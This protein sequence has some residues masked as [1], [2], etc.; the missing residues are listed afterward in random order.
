VTVTDVCGNDMEAEI[1]YEPPPPLDGVI[2]QLNLP[3]CPGDDVGLEFVLETGVGPFTYDWSSGGNGVTETVNYVDDTDV[4]LTVTDACGT[5]LDEIWPFNASLYEPPTIESETVCLGVDNAVSISELPEP[6]QPGHVPG[7]YTWFTW[8][9]TDINPITGIPG[10]SNLVEVNAQ[11]DTTVT[12]LGNLGQFSASV[13]PGTLHV[14]AVDQCGS[15]VMF[16]LEVEACDTFIPNVISPNSD[17]KNDYFRVDGIE[18]FPLSILTVYNRWGT[19]VFR[20]S[21]YRGGWDGRI[22]GRPLAEGTY[23]YV[24]QRSD[25]ENFSGPLTIVR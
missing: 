25:G 16:T 5:E 1:A 9:Y 11:L 20:D 14:T 21:D 12:F 18:G 2:E 15:E 6:G 19:Q 17:G 23:Y 8:Q 7:T 4:L 24:L 13:N 22:N 3:E 10:D